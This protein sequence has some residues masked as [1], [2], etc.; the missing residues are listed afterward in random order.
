MRKKVRKKEGRKR[1]RKTWEG[2]EKR[3]KERVVDRV[4]EWRGWGGEGEGDKEREQ[5]WLEVATANSVYA[6]LKQL[7]ALKG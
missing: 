3:K 5:R 2:R 6:D 7:P 1:T 4:E